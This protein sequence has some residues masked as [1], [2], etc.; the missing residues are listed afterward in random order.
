MSS[1]KKKG[2]TKKTILPS[3]PQKNE[4]RAQEIE[5]CQSN[6]FSL[7]LALLGRAFGS[8]VTSISPFTDRCVIIQHTTGRMG[9][10]GVNR[11]G[12]NAH[13]I[14]GPPLRDQF[15]LSLSLYA[16]CD[17]NEFCW[18][19]ERDKKKGG[20]L[21]STLYIVCV[22]DVIEFWLPFVSLSFPIFSCCYY[23]LV[24]SCFTPRESSSFFSRC[25][26]ASN[27]QADGKTLLN[28]IAKPL[29]NSSSGKAGALMVAEVQRILYLCCLLEIRTQEK[30][31]EGELLDYLEAQ[32]FSILP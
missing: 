28:T 22:D 13:T 7:L 29:L 32:A 8:I 19:R 23:F 25:A 30:K 20:P 5:R 16:I 10:V 2:A 14:E 31:R 27:N 26:F 15:L 21:Y 3:T 18:T 4:S 12:S 1:E 11:S 24:I 9:V 17:L 6:L